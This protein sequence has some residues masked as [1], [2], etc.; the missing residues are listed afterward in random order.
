MKFHKIKEVEALPP[1]QLCVQFMNGTTKKYD[2]EPLT[3]KFKAFEALNNQALFSSVKV[4][5][6][7]TELFGMMTLTFLVMNY[8]SMVLKFIPPLTT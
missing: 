7:A 2:V 5:P 4:I 8:G 3:H 1:L 6:V